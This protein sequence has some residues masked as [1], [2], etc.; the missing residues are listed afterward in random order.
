MAQ[1]VKVGSRTEFGGFGGREAR[2]SRWA[3]HRGLQCRRQLLCD[4]EYVPSS[5]VALSQKEWWWV[6]RSSALGTVPDST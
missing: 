1:F 3:S 2:R 6:K 5:G 4:R